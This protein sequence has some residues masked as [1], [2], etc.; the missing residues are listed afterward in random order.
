MK[1]DLHPDDLL[2][3]DAAGTLDDAAR[4]RL[5]AHLAVCVACRFE[6]EA[7]RDFA[8]EASD[9]VD[10]LSLPIAGALLALKTRTPSAPPPT[11]E[12]PRQ[13]SVRPAA[14]RRGLRVGL[15]VAAAMLV[16]GAAAATTG[17]MRWI[18]A[19]SPA[20]AAPPADAPE[21]PTGAA[22]VR[23]KQ[24]VVSTSA[25]TVELPAPIAAVEVAPAAPVAAEPV[26][27]APVVAPQPPPPVSPVAARV[28]T[29]VVVAP[30][31][32]ASSA[33]EPAAMLT[34]AVP[35]VAPPGPAVAPPVVAPP[36]SVVAPRSAASLFSDAN[37]ARRRGDTAR[38]IDLYRELDRAH[39][40]SAEARVARA[41][42]GKLLLEKGDAKQ[43]LERFDAYLS[44]GGGTLSE[45]ALLGRAES[46]GRMG[47]TAEERAAWQQLLRAYPA[48]P[49]AARARTRL[50]SLGG[51]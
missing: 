5:D 6:R 22:T 30:V 23:A 39:P 44:P 47:K 51:P 21:L 18:S 50:A 15:L 20:V 19:S 29:P 11:A 35:A 2:D 16:V 26:A 41:T 36:P 32:E 25:A 24:R 17:A 4:A 43:A 37:D 12:P 14:A 8:L 48:S 28:S 38:A 33:V 7:R 10:R 1:I 31:R 46:L 45:E 40:H 34:A 27:V 42:M 49:H 9:D 3:R 13:P